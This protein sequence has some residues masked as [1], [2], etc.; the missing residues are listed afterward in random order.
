[1]FSRIFF[2]NFKKSNKLSNW[3]Y[4]GLLSTFFISGLTKA[5]VT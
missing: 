4:S 3:A 5:Y 1:M 2:L